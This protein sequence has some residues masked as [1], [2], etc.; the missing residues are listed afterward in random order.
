MKCSTRWRF[1]HHSLQQTVRDLAEQGGSTCVQVNRRTAPRDNSMSRVMTERN[2][3]AWIGTRGARR[4]QIVCMKGAVPAG[5]QESWSAE[6]HDGTRPA[7]RCWRYAAGGV[8][9]TGGIAL[10]LYRARYLSRPRRS[11][12]QSLRASGTL[13][14]PAVRAVAPWV[15][16]TRRN[17]SS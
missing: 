1:L 5:T 9:A 2:S 12:V 3:S 16:A 13:R 6:A 10:E 8:Q 14:P 15:H 11:A 17:S 4:V 7:G